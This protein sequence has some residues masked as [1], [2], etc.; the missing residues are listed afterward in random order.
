MLLS[1]AW[2]G[3]K[4]DWGMGF[5][6]YFH[7]VVPHNSGDRCRFSQP[8][9]LVV[10]LMDNVTAVSM[11]WRAIQQKGVYEDAFNLLTL[12]PP[13]SDKHLISPYSIT[14]G[15][16]IRVTRIKEMITKLGCSWILNKFSLSPT[17]GNVRRTVW[18][19]CILILGCKELISDS[20]CPM[21]HSAFKRLVLFLFVRVMVNLLDG[22]YGKKQW[23]SGDKF[24]SK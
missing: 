1:W 24:P 13:E 9:A 19:I 23:P 22:G 11:K 4:H 14:P 12:W 5:S 21:H 2:Q 17:L 8:L 18:R 16:H 7:S 20:S 6:I 15:S 3:Q 10:R